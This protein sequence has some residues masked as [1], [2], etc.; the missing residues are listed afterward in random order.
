MS[1]TRVIIHSVIRFLIRQPFAGGSSPFPI[2]LLS[3][4]SLDPLTPLRQLLAKNI[5][6]ASL[7]L[8]VVVA[9]CASS[10]P[11][12]G[13]SSLRQACPSGTFFDVESSRCAPWGDATPL[14]AAGEKALT[15]GEI[16][17]AISEFAKAQTAKPHPYPT[18]VRLYE[19]LGIAYSYA[20]DESKAKAAFT[21]LLRLD[22]NHLISYNTSPQAT[23]KFEDARNAILNKPTPE[24]S[25]NWPDNAEV[26]RKVPIEIEVIADPDHMLERATLYL[27]DRTN[28]NSST[29]AADIVLEPKGKRATI[30]LPALGGNQ[31]RNLAVYL[32][33][34]DKTASE[35]LLWASE[36]QPR[37]LRLGYTEPEPLYKKW[38]VLTIAGA[39]LI[40][41]GGSAAY[42][43]FRDPPSLVNQGGVGSR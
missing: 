25:V 5:A 37:S 16:D 18:H 12:R 19:Q 14:I 2:A 40:G 8:C 32:V 39:V 4:L 15:E 21:R 28:E 42:F 17:V 1:R 11:L 43:I 6:I 9:S 13:L 23:L 34:R 41:G 20:G 38:W 36:S 22:P 10:P 3:S 7:S 30:N 24:I 29:H 35:V 27:R 33:A 26:R 31:S